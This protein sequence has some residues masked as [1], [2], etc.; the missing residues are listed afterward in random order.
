VTTSMLIYYWDVGLVL[1]TA[2]P[3]C[4]GS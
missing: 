1:A 4:S 2:D 3:S